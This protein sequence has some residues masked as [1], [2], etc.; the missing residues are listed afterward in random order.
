M[1]AERIRSLCALCRSR[2]V[3]FVN[4]VFNASSS[5]RGGRN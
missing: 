3:G 1:S 4:D 5:V 2:C